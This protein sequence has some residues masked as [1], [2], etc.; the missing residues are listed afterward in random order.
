MHH[1]SATTCL[2][3]GGWGERA[4]RGGIACLPPLALPRHPSRLPSSYRPQSTDS[5]ERGLRRERAREHYWW[6]SAGVQAGRDVERQPHDSGLR[7]N[8][9]G[10]GGDGRSVDTGQTDVIADAHGSLK[11][12]PTRAYSPGGPAHAPAYWRAARQT[13]TGH[14]QDTYSWVQEKSIA[15]STV[16][17][18]TRSAAGP[19]SRPAGARVGGNV[20]KLLSIFPA[21]FPRRRDETTAQRTRCSH[22]RGRRGKGAGP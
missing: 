7:R 12:P 9:L 4:C 10:C 17:L 6:A 8:D 14:V 21:S 19:S 18:G 1:C 20:L 3:T 22:R 2:V 11:H 15:A 16:S 13:R 5:R